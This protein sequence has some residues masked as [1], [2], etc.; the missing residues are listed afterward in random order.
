MSGRHND[1]NRAACLRPSPTSDSTPMTDPSDAIAAVTHPDPYPY[2]ARLVRERPASRDPA[3][4]TWVFASAEAVSA[5][6]T[7]PACRVRAANEPAPPALAGSPAGDVFGRMLRMRDDPARAAVRAA[8]GTAL[9]TLGASEIET[10]ARRAIGLL[11]G[12]VPSDAGLAVVADD[13]ASRLPALTVATLLGVRDED[14]SSVARDATAFA[15]AAAGSSAADRA[16]G[17]R[18]VTSLLATLRATAASAGRTASPGLLAR[19]GAAAGAAGVDDEVLLANA[20]GLLFQA[21]DATAGLIG[22]AV[23]AL[24]RDPALERAVRANTAPM[25]AVLMEVARHDA[26]VQNTRRFVGEDAVVFG[27][28]LRAGDAMLVV[29][30]AANRD[31]SANAEPGRFLATRPSARCFTFGLGVHACLAREL[32]L[33]IAGAGV[34]HVLDHAEDLA[35]LAGAGAS[36]SY[37]PSVNV[38]APCF[39]SPSLARATP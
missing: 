2:Y 18:T 19:L 1:G 24:A 22:G 11:R 36:P 30:G 28:P 38:R 7:H 3:T 8:S 27:R 39:S 21:H 16:D 14:A 35:S 17:N 12:S 29:L 6:L 23:L 10:A 15:R 5:A 37:R 13:C 4:G 33:H 9:G 25:R 32:A 20:V 26:P 31:P 34:R